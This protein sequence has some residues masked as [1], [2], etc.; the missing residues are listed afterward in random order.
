MRIMLS[1]IVFL[2]CQLFYL[3]WLRRDSASEFINKGLV[4]FI[5]GREKQEKYIV[6]RRI[7]FDY[8]IIDEVS[9][10]HNNDLCYI[11]I[12]RCVDL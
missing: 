2:Q 8:R 5:Q 11:F 6:I 12:V 3:G 4:T 1:F 9:L 7:D 10:F